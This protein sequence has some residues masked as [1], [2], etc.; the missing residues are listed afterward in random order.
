MRSNRKLAWAAAVVAVFA[1]GLVQHG[2]ADTNPART[3]YLTFS[4]PVQLPGVALGAGTYL[5]E[6]AD[7][8]AA[9]GVVRVL[10]RDRRIAYTWASPM[11]PRVPVDCV[12]MRRCRSAKRRSGCHRE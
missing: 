9:P 1:L 3:T 10:S 4:Q 2:A 7:P 5:F 11:G 8:D 6:L 12:Q